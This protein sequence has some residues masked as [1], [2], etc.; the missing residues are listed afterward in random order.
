MDPIEIALII[1][2]ERKKC[3]NI[4]KKYY[5]KHGNESVD[6]LYNYLQSQLEKNDDTIVIKE[7]T[8]DMEILK[9]YLKDN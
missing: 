9:N 6:K 1:E 7:I 5:N 2:E 3:L 8:Y 4:I